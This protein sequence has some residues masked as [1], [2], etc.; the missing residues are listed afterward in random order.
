MFRLLSSA[1]LLFLTKQEIIQHFSELFRLDQPGWT[2]PGWGCCSFGKKTA[3]TPEDVVDCGGVPIGASLQPVTS[4]VHS[5]WA[6]EIYPD[7][8]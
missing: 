1:R 8:N 5:R 6:R 2:F 4:T 7:K 3:D